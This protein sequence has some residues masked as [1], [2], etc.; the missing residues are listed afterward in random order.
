M[1][2]PSPTILVARFLK[3]NNYTQTL[4]AFIEEAGLSKTNL[5][6]SLTPAEN[7]TWSIENIVKEKNT[8]DKSLSFDRAHE[9]DVGEERWSEPGMHYSVPPAGRPMV[10]PRFS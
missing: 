2:S 10:L 6:A 4:S 3:S 5:N 1:P 9:G 8:F 7:Y